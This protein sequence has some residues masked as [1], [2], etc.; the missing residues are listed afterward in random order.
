MISHFE[1]FAVDSYRGDYGFADYHLDPKCHDWDEVVKYAADLAMTPWFWIASR[2]SEVVVTPELAS[3]K[4]KHPLWTKTRQYKFKNN[5][6]DGWSSFRLF[7][8]KTAKTVPL[9]DLPS[10]TRYFRGMTPSIKEHPVFFVSNGE[11]NAEENWKQLSRLYPS[12][13]RITGVNGRWNMFDRCADLSNGKDFFVVTG[14]NWVTNPEIFAF[15]P[16]PL[17][18]Q[19]WV[20]QAYN[21]TNNLMYGHMGIVLY[22]YECIR[23]TPRNFGLDFT[24]F[25]PV[26]EVPVVASEARFATSPYEAW[27]T[28]FRECVKLTTYIDQD[29]NAKW[30]LETWR[31]RAKGPNAAWSLM[32]AND[33]YEYA[34]MYSGISSEKLRLTVEWDWL[35]KVWEDKYGSEFT[36]Q[37]TINGDDPKSDDRARNNI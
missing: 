9:S 33:G 24:M 11:S 20:F 16:D 2:P 10:E 1:V 28:A 6:G 37:E 34:K 8:T 3:F 19:H 12:A 23:N 5:V 4:P 30:R 29:P 13:I 18:K 14:K 7:H 27:R 17:A 25:S 36:S 32:G 15:Q 22:N 31:T 26:H 35:R 21:V